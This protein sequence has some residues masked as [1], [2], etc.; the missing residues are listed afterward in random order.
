MFHGST[1]LVDL[2]PLIL[3]LSV[4]YTDTTFDANPLEE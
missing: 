2:G 1:S 4:S 3:E